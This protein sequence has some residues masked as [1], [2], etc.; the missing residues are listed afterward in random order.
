MTKQIQDLP[1][2]SEEA[3]IELLAG[4]LETTPAMFDRLAPKGFEN[5]SYYFYFQNSPENEYLVYRRTRA[6]MYRYSRQ[7][8]KKYTVTPLLSFAQWLVD[9]YKQSPSI[10]PDEPV[11]ILMDVFLRLT[12]KGILF[13]RGIGS[14]N[15]QMDGTQ[16][17]E[18][19]LDA[20]QRANLQ[21]SPG[22]SFHRWMR[23]PYRDPDA[24]DA[25]G[26]YLHIF[27]YLLTRGIEFAHR[28]NYL[29]FVLGL[30]RELEGKLPG[31][32]MGEFEA[33]ANLLHMD[34]PDQYQPAGG[35]PDFSTA[36]LQSANKNPDELLLVYKSVYRVWPE[37]YPLR[38]G[39]YI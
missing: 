4:L 29:E 38:I 2:L 13:D 15:F 34:E 24:I 22:Y 30:Q 28:D 11:S 10:L 19:I 6:G 7:T 35:Y 31:A 12:N 26:I 14:F 16:A 37:G 36:F 27:E 25:T 39:D 9:E 5:S 20:L 21:V 23:H 1:L 3:H 33:L 8:G 17:D 32:E 18:L